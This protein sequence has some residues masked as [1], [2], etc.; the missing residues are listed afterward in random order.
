[1]T[2]ITKLTRS[3]SVCIAESI[4]IFS[5][6]AASVLT[7]ILLSIGNSNAEP[8]KTID[9][10]D[11]LNSLDLT[12]QIDQDFTL[13]CPRGKTNDVWIFGTD[14]YGQLSRICIAAVHAG[15]IT[16]NGG[17]FTI[18]IKPGEDMYNGLLQNGVDSN[19]YSGMEASFIFIKNGQPFPLKG[20]IGGIKI[21]QDIDISSLSLNKQIDRDFTFICLL[22]IKPTRS[23][24]PLAAR[25]PSILCWKTLEWTERY[26]LISR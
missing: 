22:G 17:T 15:A 13:T 12:K 7:V 19:S 6:I 24:P 18:R 9:W 16:K 23:L 5:S 25:G 14:I 8:V 4:G 21:I 11:D 10:G 20:S 26:Y 1:M 2:S 3:R